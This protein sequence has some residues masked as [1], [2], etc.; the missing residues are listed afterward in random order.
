[1]ATS[2]LEWTSCGET[3]ETELYYVDYH[4]KPDET[5]TEGGS[6]LKQ[7]LCDSCI[8]PHVSKGLNV[9]TAKG[10]TPLIC[11]SH[12]KLHNFYCRS[13]DCTFC[14]KCLVAKHAN[15]EIGSIE[16]RA[17]ELK[18]EVLDSFPVC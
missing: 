18:K 2:Q 14:P 11:D 10:Q 1:M 17:S 7:L 3:E 6:Q 4:T 9:K 8:A 5:N 13:C 12:K 16:E 15:H